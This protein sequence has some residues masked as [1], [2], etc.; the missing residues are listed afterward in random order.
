MLQL[1][2]AMKAVHTSKR[3]RRVQMAVG[4]AGGGPEVQSGATGI[5]GAGALAHTGAT[6]SIASSTR[7]KSELGS[8][9]TGGTMAQSAAAMGGGAVEASM[10]PTAAGEGAE[11]LGGEMG[12]SE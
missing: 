2:V 12:A 9:A 8:V 4:T 7:R 11:R 10:T 1:L 3:G 6:S 5:S